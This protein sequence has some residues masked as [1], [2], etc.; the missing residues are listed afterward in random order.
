VLQFTDAERIPVACNLFPTV[1]RQR[2]LEP[3][4]KATHN[5]LTGQTTIRKVNTAS[6]YAWK[7]GK[8]I[9]KDTPMPEVLNKLSNYYNVKFVV[10][11]P[12]INSYPFTGTFD[13]RQLSQVLDYFKHT[14][15]ITYTLQQVTEDESSDN[16]HT[17]VILD[18]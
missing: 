15:N 17:I 10:R 9:F 16:K 11:N 7:D 14:S 1:L 6:E 3:D 12:V 4:E 8:L 2:K 18:K 13:N 5:F